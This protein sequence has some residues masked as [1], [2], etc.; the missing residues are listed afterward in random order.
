MW[1]CPRCEVLNEDHL[2]ECEVCFYSKSSTTSVV[3]DTWICPRCETINVATQDVCEVCFASKLDLEINSTEIKRKRRRLDIDNLEASSVDSNN[4][5]NSALSEKEIAHMDAKFE[6]P[7]SENTEEVS[8]SPIPMEMEFEEKP[9]ETTVQNEPILDNAGWLETTLS[10]ASKAEESED[11]PSYKE[12]PRKEPSVDKHKNIKE[13]KMGVQD[14]LGIAFAVI[15]LFS[16]PLCAAFIGEWG[17][18]LG[19]HLRLLFD[20]IMYTIN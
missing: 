16:L 12:L 2:D 5:V 20:W 6:E 14:W 10:L 8:N 11:I 13:P 18:D 15:L 4:T 7:S 17:N 1:K 3:E 19:L 9:T